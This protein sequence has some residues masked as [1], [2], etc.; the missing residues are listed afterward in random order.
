MYV[1]L[2]SLSF[3]QQAY[4]VPQQSSTDVSNAIHHIQI[5]SEDQLRGNV[6]SLEWCAVGTKK[7][8]GEK[9][10]RHYF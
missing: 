10:W 7:H 2:Q 8:R 5:V 9:G 1:V 4:A 3:G 6:I